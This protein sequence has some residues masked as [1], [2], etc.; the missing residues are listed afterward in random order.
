MIVL[1]TAAMPELLAKGASVNKDC[2]T[3]VVELTTTVLG[4]ASVNKDCETRVVKLTT[5]VLGAE[6]VEV[7]SSSTA[8]FALVDATKTVEGTEVVTDVTKSDVGIDVAA[9]RFPV[10]SV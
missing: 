10:I 4:S 6:V 7:V 2:G 9:L 3:A 8:V 1:V 5:A